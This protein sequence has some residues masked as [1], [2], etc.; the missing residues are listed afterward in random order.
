M[1]GHEVARRLRRL[2]GLGSIFLVALTGYGQEEDR[3]R[4][5]QAG[6]DA[7]LIK[8]ADPLALQQLLA[9]AELCARPVPR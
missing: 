9:E 4:A 1:D 8:P 5:E 7:H 2:A 3:R 6:F